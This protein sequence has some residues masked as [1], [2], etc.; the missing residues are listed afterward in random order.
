MKKFKKGL[1]CFILSIALVFTLT[2]GIAISADDE[3]V[4]SKISDSLREEMANSETVQIFVWLEDSIKK[5]DVQAQVFEELKIGE[6]EQK[7]ILGEIEDGTVEDDLLNSY[8]ER[9]NDVYSELYIKNNSEL[10]D[11]YFKDEKCLFMSVLAP[12]AVFEVES[13]KVGEIAQYEEVAFLDLYELKPENLLNTSLPLIKSNIV[14]NTYGYT[15]AG[16]KIGQVEVRVPD[17]TVN[18]VV[19][20]NGIADSTF[21]TVHATNVARIINN[22]APDAQIYS[23]STREYYTLSNVCENAEGFTPAVEW[24]ITTHNVNIINSSYTPNGT[25]NTYDMFC[26]WADHISIN[27][28]VHF[29]QAAGNAGD[30][31]V[32]TPGMAYNVIT[33]GNLDDKNSLNSDLHTIC[34]VPDNESSFSSL[35]EDADEYFA[36]K[37]DLCAPGTYISYNG[38]DMGIGTSYSTAHVSGA[39]A[40]MCEQKNTL[41]VQQ[42]TVK[43][44]L[45]ATTDADS[46]HYYTPEYWAP[47]IVNNYSH[48]GA[49]VLNCKNAYTT[50]RYSRYYNGSFT[51]AQVSA[52]TTH[53]YS[54]NVTSGMTHIRVALASLCTVTNYSHYVQQYSSTGNNHQQPILDLDIYIY[55]NGVLIASSEIGKGN[56]EIIDFDPRDYGTGTY[57]IK[58]VPYS[59]SAVSTNT[60]YTVAWW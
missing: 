2:G 35:G 56:I 54:M 17:N 40:L 29:V 25:K 34:T 37:P 20:R 21:E 23:A 31:G 43:A 51:P 24:L 19:V 26:L 3:T 12:M 50:I 22:V 14:N 47:S 60:F 1:V 55:Y 18:N 6:K 4:A 39:I 30:Y 57:T 16:V 11:K 45:S 36:Y 52:G 49:G 27:H 13:S 15:G 44:I 38:T 41:K 59:P 42:R 46:P 8:I 33:V 53:S 5:E 7:M 28:D 10:V 58:V 9:K 48:F 32:L